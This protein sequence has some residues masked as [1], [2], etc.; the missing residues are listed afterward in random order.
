MVKFLD[1]LLFFFLI[2]M[3][4]GSKEIYKVL[5]DTKGGIKKYIYIIFLLIT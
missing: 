1:L 3:G 4:H 2:G 5:G